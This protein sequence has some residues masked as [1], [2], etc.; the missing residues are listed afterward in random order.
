[1]TTEITTRDDTYAARYETADSYAQFA[2]EGGPGIQGKLLT[3]K[4]GVWGIGQD[5]TPPPVG[6]RYLFIAD[7]MMRGWLKWVGGVIVDADMGLVVDNFRVKHRDALG[8]LEEEEWEKTP[9]AKPRDPWSKAY[10]A[11]LIELS[12]PARRTDL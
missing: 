12:P 9:D 10:R 6:A 11:L 7:T 8:D 1:M 2:N 3:C 4:K 5:C